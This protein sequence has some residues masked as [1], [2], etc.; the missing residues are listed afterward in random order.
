MLN[1]K[2]WWWRYWVSSNNE[3]LDLSVYCFISSHPVNDAWKHFHL[4]VRWIA[5]VDC[6]R[7]A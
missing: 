1:R 7:P 3:H 5:S 2:K 6:I 4:C